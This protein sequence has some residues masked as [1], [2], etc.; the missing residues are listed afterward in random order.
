MSA[1]FADAFC[2]FVLFS[3]P[4]HSEYQPPTACQIAESCLG[5]I[6]NSVANSM[7]PTTPYTDTANSCAAGYIG[8]RCARCDLA[9]YMLNERCYLS[10]ARQQLRAPS[11][12]AL[13]SPSFALSCA[14]ILAQLR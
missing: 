1:R 10:V 8:V 11:S 14:L 3:A 12:S 9:F 7:S 5:V 2:Y 6:A 13:C 4:V